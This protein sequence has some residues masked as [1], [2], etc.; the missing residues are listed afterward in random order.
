MMIEGNGHG[1]DWNGQYS[2]GLLDAFAR[3]RRSR[4][5]DLSESCRLVLLLGEHMKHDH[6][7][8][9]HARGQTL[10]RGG[11]GRPTTPRGRRST[12]W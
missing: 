7:G 4:P 2:V 3:G 10:Q 1:A 9:Y 5:N 11:E 8:R 6:H 12:C